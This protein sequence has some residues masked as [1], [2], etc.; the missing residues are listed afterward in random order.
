MSIGLS[1]EGNCAIVLAMVLIC[2][3]DLWT[4]REGGFFVFQP[5][6]SDAGH[7][8]VRQKQLRNFFLIIYVTKYA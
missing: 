4:R 7:V 8:V 5:P 2:A 1:G 3:N 6:F